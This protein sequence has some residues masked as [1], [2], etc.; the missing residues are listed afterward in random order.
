[1]MALFIDIGNIGEMIILSRMRGKKVVVLYFVLSL[2][3]PF[4]HSFSGDG[5]NLV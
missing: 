3:F 2:R 1:M 4:R 5:K